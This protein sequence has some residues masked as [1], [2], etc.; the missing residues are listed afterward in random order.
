MDPLQILQISVYSKLI[1]EYSSSILTDKYNLLLCGGLFVCYKLF[2]TEY[3]TTALNDILNLFNENE[4]SII[5]PQHTKIYKTYTFSGTKEALQ[6]IYSDRFQSLNHYLIKNMNVQNCDINSMI[7][8]VKRDYTTYNENEK[9][10]F[11]LLPNQKNK[12][13]ICNEHDIF[14]EIIMKEDELNS[15]EKDGKKRNVSEKNY[16]YK[17]TKHGRQ[18]YYVLEEFMKKCLKMYKEDT[19]DE[20][21]QYIFEL[22]KTDKDEDDRNRVVFKKYE[23]H[24][25]KYLDKNIFFE[26]KAG[27]IEYI[28][29]FVRKTQNV[30]KSKHE[31]EYEDSGVTFKAGII[32]HGPPG[33][34]K[35][36]TIKGI[37]NR[38]NRHGI[39][40]QWSKIK[41]CSELCS[42]IR[43]PTIDNK[44]YSLKDVCF[45]IE[46]FDANNNDVLK[47]RVNKEQ[48]VDIDIEQPVNL[49]M[50]NQNV[51]ISNM[52]T[53]ELK[54]ELIKTKQSFE[55]M[56][57][58]MTRRID[59]E[60]TLE[61][62]LNVMDGIVELHDAML[63]FT[64]NHIEKIDPAFMRPGR[65]DYILELKPATVRVI[66]E[67]IEYKF[68]A[69]NIDFEKYT[70]YFAKMK[71]C[72]ISPAEV[73]NIC[74][75]YSHIDIEASSSLPLVESSLPLV[76][77]SLPLVEASLP[78]VEA[79][80]P[81][82]E[83]CLNELLSKIVLITNRH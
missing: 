39:L 1:N 49:N 80:L 35:S 32:M 6:T 58:Q 5:I 63:I 8:V 65:I 68:R 31:L 2:T 57:T 44:A 34:G 55:N 81:L 19:N 20:T 16:T 66:R 79:S 70:E 9:M 61:C 43:N 22:V 36:C 40:L 33:C 13:K 14:F 50:P 10:D 56:V 74:F 83:Q 54:S 11:I 41:T 72:V 7:E 76:E 69:L 21:Q 28:D 25:N 4:C 47:S 67:M 23:F 17:I 26:Q 52:N 71:D 64:T 51:D 46:D 60:L 42:I 53:N 27:F 78:L 48:L 18:N 37:L 62:V 24:S 45:I 30:E 59:D 12:I 38:T 29:R 3:F 15:T 82:V 73:Q 77:A 75:K